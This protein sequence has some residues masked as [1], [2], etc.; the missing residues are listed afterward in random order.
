[1]TDVAMTWYLSRPEKRSMDRAIP[2]FHAA[3]N[4]KLGGNE[5][6]PTSGR[7]DPDSFEKKPGDRVRLIDAIRQRLLD[8]P[9]RPENEARR[10]Y[11]IKELE[12]ALN[13]ERLRAL[14]SWWES[15]Q[16]GAL[17]FDVPAPS[18]RMTGDRLMSLASTARI[19]CSVRTTT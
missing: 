1:V 6:V 12:R 5:P 8:I 10:S 18:R 4:W 2:E 7:N 19:G 17:G 11:Y 15:P 16:G 3:K 9:D 13:Y 14:K